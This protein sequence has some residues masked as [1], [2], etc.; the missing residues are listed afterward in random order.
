MLKGQKCLSAKCH[1]HPAKKRPR[2]YPPG[3]RG[4]RRS[5][6]ISAFGVQLRAKQKYRRMYGVL[7]R[8]FR[9]YFRE[10]AR[11]R[12]V[13]GET[14]V[15]LLERRLDNVVY[16]LGFALSR[17]HAR[18]LVRHN[19]I[20]ING[21]RATIPSQLVKVGEE[22]SIRDKSRQMPVIEEA[23][24]LAMTLESCPWMSRDE[25]RMAGHLVRL[26]RLDEVQLP[27]GPQIIVELYSK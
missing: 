3:E 15:Q 13:T 11:K 12:G 17:A 1:F 24:R 6:K 8:Q 25:A 18:Q 16:R 5:A 20:L 14:L 2:P 27:V 19:H 10:A 26:P 21:K 9:R 23:L 22:V 4:Q 7:E